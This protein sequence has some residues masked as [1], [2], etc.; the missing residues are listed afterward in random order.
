MRAF[1]ICLAALGA[2]AAARSVSADG[3][4]TARLSDSGIIVPV[5]ERGA[6]V[7]DQ[8]VTITLP[9]PAGAW[10][11]PAVVRAEY[12]LFNEGRNRLRISVGW[13]TGGMR[14]EGGHPHPRCRPAVKFD[15]KPLACE[16]LSFNALA[17]AYAAPW[18]ERIVQLLESKP[19]LK[20]QVTAVREEGAR[21]G[22]P[23]LRG[24]GAH[25]LARWMRDNGLVAD[26]DSAHALAGGLLGV[27]PYNH[28]GAD[29]SFVQQALKWLDPAYQPINLYEILSERWG[30]E[31]LLLD[32]NSGQ[33]VDVRADMLQHEPL[34][35]VFRF[36]IAL[37]PNSKHHLAVQYGQFL[38]GADFFE[39][40][41]YGLVYLM[42]PAKRWGRWER[43]AIEIRV[44]RGWQRVAIRPPA[45]RTQT[46]G[47][48]AL[49]RILM[50][51]PYENLYVSAAP[52]I[53]RAKLWALWARRLFDAYRLG[54]PE[55]ER[56]KAEQQ[57]LEAGRRPAHQALASLLGD[58]SASHRSRLQVAF[59]MAL[60]NLD[61]RAGSAVLLQ[62]LRPE[63]APAP[64][65]DVVR[66]ISQVYL[67]VVDRRLL[68]GLLEA[69]PRTD[70]AAADVMAGIFLKL[71]RKDPVRLLQGLKNKSDAVWHAVCHLLAH[72]TEGEPPSKAVPALAQIA[73]RPSDPLASVA[74]RLLRGVAQASDR[75]RRHAT[76]PRLEPLFPEPIR[77]LNLTEEAMGVLTPK[78]PG[79]H[80]MGTSG[81]DDAV[82]RQVRSRSGE[83]AG[84]QYCLGDFDGND[85]S[86]TALLIRSSGT[87]KLIVLRQVDSDQWT[88]DELTSFRFGAGFQ[89]GYARFTIYI[90]AHPPG[91][92]AF[93]ELPSDEKTGRLELR[94]E[95]IELITA[96][97]ASV[98]YYWSGRGYSTIHDSD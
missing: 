22:K 97:K 47:G 27:R 51:R 87:V 54:L 52:P 69:A 57:I 36:S 17:N 62:Y 65:E 15:G 10:R 44:P 33:L 58:K 11:E 41:W 39:S 59:A 26:L 89:G 35:A 23:W 78:Y 45:D 19:A 56:D 12:V 18:I 71:A 61:Y 74:K 72:E 6:H 8:R 9:P 7:L 24:D 60:L 13:P 30:H 77:G 28:S 2:L 37:E 63:K 32:P 93:W 43:T 86:D 1:L 83:Q 80:V 14:Y 95:G 81:F 66:L 68:D 90:A 55:L 42:E 88:V 50:R 92:V 34:F 94:H 5:D 91:T 64:H 82:V 46:R 73:E 29:A 85:A 70:G 38:G 21:R 16:L 25:G 76:Q 79:W 3:E 67:R 75:M 84:P 48:Y 31:A 96:G 20:Q 53:P 40:P 4:P 49:Y 98:L